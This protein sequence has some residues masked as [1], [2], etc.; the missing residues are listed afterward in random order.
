MTSKQQSSNQ[1]PSSNLDSFK[2][3]AIAKIYQGKP[4]TKGA[5]LLFNWSD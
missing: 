5:R 2:R 4:L 3:D 1:K